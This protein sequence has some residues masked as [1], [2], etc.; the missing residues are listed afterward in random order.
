MTRDYTITIDGTPSTVTMRA[1]LAQASAPIQHVYE[2]EW[3]GETVVAD[4]GYQT[5]DAR[6]DLLAA[7]GLLIDRVLPDCDVLDVQ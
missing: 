5:A 1:D 2:D 3:S 4:T 7:A 6:H